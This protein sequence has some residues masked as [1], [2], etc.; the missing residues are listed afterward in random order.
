MFTWHD[1]ST[2]EGFWVKGKKEGVGVFRPAF[3]RKAANLSAS[4]NSSLLHNTN[5]VGIPETTISPMVTSEKPVDSPTVSREPL[6]R[7]SSEHGKKNVDVVY[8]CDYSHGKLSHEEA[9]SSHE[10]DVIF[11]PIQHQMQ[12]KRRL[13][14]R[15]KRRQENMGETIFKGHRSYD[16]MLNLQ[17]GIRYTLT[18]LSKVSRP[19]RLIDRHFKEK[20]WLRFPRNGS[21]VTPPHPSNDFKWKDYCPEAFR[22]LRKVFNINTSDYLLSLCGDQALREL[23]SPGKSGSVFYISHDEQYMIKTVRKEEIKLLLNML[24]KYVEHVRKHPATMLLRFFGV[25]RVRPSQGLKVRFVVMNN[26]FRT[27]VPLHAK[28]DLKGSTKGRT[29]GSRMSATAVRKDLDLDVRFKLD[30][31][32]RARLIDQLRQDCSFLEGM[33][34][35]DYS[36]LLG[37]HYRSHGDTSASP[38]NTDRE[39]EG[40]GERLLA[41][42]EL[43]KNSDLSIQASCG[44]PSTSEHQHSI[45]GERVLQQMVDD[46]IES[47][48]VQSMHSIDLGEYSIKK[49]PSANSYAPLPFLRLWGKSR[50]QSGEVQRQPSQTDQPTTAK[51]LQ[52]PQPP[53]DGMPSFTFAASAKLSNSQPNALQE[54]SQHLSEEIQH[55]SVNK[56]SES[57]TAGLGAAEGALLHTAEGY[58][59][60]S[61][62]QQHPHN[63]KVADRISSSECKNEDGTLD[64]SSNKLP[65]Q[66]VSWRS[67][68][69]H[70]PD[71]L[72]SSAVQQQTSDMVRTHK[73]MPQG[74]GVAS[75]PSVLAHLPSIPSHHSLQE[76]GA[77]VEGMAQLATDCWSEEFAK[78]Q[79]HEEGAPCAAETDVAGPC[80]APT[81]ARQSNDAGHRAPVAAVILG[82]TKSAPASSFDAYAVTGV[83]LHGGVHGLRSCVPPHVDAPPTFKRMASTGAKLSGSVSKQTTA[84]VNPSTQETSEIIARMSRRLE[85]PVSDR[86]LTDLIKLAKYKMLDRSS[87]ARRF[88][89]PTMVLAARSKRCNSMVSRCDDEL[90][91]SPNLEQPGINVSATAISGQAGHQ[92]E[93][94]VLFCGIIDFLQEYNFRKMLEH[95]FKA[96]VQDGQAISVVEP[97]AYSRRFLNFMSGVFISEQH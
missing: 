80:S 92:P 27:D 7:D 62:Q 57:T 12:T 28:Y 23:P 39:D 81:S 6:T 96:V 35:M 21:E 51:Q 60:S 43:Q 14:R 95:N 69:V 67:N 88:R 29:I 71:L 17:L 32:Q 52:A 86:L 82:R 4:A 45:P 78:W 5:D 73:E 48:A 33:H 93:D 87:A 13:R 1:G 90:H 74:R 8:V 50:V 9:L 44:E 26:V 18:T 83:R 25:H 55:A 72:S 76:S 85:R 68:A 65:F 10:L 56:K 40:G 20:V 46:D 66:P 31:N 89:A 64:L 77:G 41:N 2:F 24:P 97:R 15:G 30:N 84:G 70:L 91:E 94:V 47:E 54:S 16:L 75:G 34:V 19:P 3:E 79:V 49:E 37:V 11:G 63:N 36:L 53:A 22:E 59:E 42:L 61:L 38:I 58:H